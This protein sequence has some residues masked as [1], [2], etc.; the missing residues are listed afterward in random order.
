MWPEV[1]FYSID[2]L[3]SFL[4]LVLEENHQRAVHK[5]QA[6]NWFANICVGLTYMF[7][8]SLLAIASTHKLRPD[9]ERNLK[10]DGLL[11]Q[12]IFCYSLNYCH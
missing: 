5:R 12:I 11:F 6:Y 4:Y 9:Y 1:K 10:L 8:F 7:S 2:V 3:P